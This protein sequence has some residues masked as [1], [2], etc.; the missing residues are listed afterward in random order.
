M[1]KIWILKVDYKLCGLVWIFLYWA[2]AKSTEGPCILQ[3]SQGRERGIVP[4][5]SFV[6]FTDLSEGDKVYGKAPKLVATSGFQW[7]EVS[8]FPNS[9]Y[10]AI[11]ACECPGKSNSGIT[12]GQRRRNASFLDTFN[13][14]NIQ[15]YP[16]S[17]SE[18]SKE[19]SLWWEWVIYHIQW[20]WK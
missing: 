20:I 3:I 4:S 2:A 1:T 16:N 19:R 8:K 10:E 6:K 15:I 11:A 14:F 12:L 7:F 13:S 9:G 5:Q 17:T 18:L